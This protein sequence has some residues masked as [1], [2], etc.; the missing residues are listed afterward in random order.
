MLFLC[1]L[2]GSLFFAFG[3][4]SQLNATGD[5]LVSEDGPPFSKGVR[6]IL[7][8]GTTVSYADKVSFDE[9]KSRQAEL[10]AERA[11]NTQVI[12][13][14]AFP[15]GYYLNTGLG[16][17]I[18][19]GFGVDLNIEANQL[20][21]AY[22]I[23][24]TYQDPDLQYDYQRD[25]QAIEELWSAKAMIFLRFQSKRNVSFRIG[26]G[27]NAPLRWI[28][29]SEKSLK[30]FA[31]GDLLNQTLSTNR[32]MEKSQLALET[33]NYVPVAQLE[34]GIPLNKHMS[35]VIGS[36][37]VFAS[38]IGTLNSTWISGRIGINAHIGR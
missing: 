6:L 1:L 30:E 36:E 2:G 23:R 17:S 12:G 38:S 20:K 5:S 10:E 28:T 18:S 16:F 7:G 11:I 3:Q 27:V 32:K 19:R 8:I 9:V 34:L 13:R 22:L 37:G 14:L 29:T 35:I 26:G 4:T 25:F 31:N 21:S 15:L 24:E 33:I